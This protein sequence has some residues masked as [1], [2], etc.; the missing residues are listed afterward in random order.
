MITGLGTSFISKNWITS[1]VKILYRFALSAT[2][3]VFFQNSDDKKIFLNNELVNPKICKL[4]PG[5]G[6]DLDQFS[7]SPMQENSKFTFLLIA[8]MIWDKGIGDFVEA[9]RLIIAKYPNTRF[10]LLGPL[11]VSNRT[12]ISHRTMSE[13]EQDGFIEYL[14]ESSN[15][16]PNIQEASCI[17]LPSYRE[18]TSRVLLEAAAIGRPII[19]TDV[20]GCREVVKNNINGLLCRPKDH[21]DLSHKMEIMINLSFEDRKK[22]GIRGRE[23]IENEFNQE[24]VNDLYTFAIEN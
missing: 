1:L 6:I 16:I 17:V 22:M 12:S 7:L 10:H 8:R 19:T 4:T 3:T 9:A 18:G 20:P 2:S 13:W 11:G 5:S 15:V 24:I 21:H 14:G 23:I